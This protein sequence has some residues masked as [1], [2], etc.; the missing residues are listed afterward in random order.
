MDPLNKSKIDN[1]LCTT[2]SCNSDNDEKKIKCTKCKRFV[3][4]VCVHKFDDVYTS[5]IIFYKE[6][7][8][9]CMCQLRKKYERISIIVQKARRKYD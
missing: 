5:C 1:H 9:I 4:F 8:A 2:T 7:L 6:L 3:H